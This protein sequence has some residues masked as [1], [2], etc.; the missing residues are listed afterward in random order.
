L[1][2]QVLRVAQHKVGVSDRLAFAS[3]IRV[4]EP[5][6]VQIIAGKIEPHDAHLKSRS[7]QRVPPI[8]APEIQ[9]AI[10]SLEPEVP[11]KINID[12]VVR[13][14]RTAATAYPRASPK[15]L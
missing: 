9:H 3:Q 12:N 10:P 7:L 1:E 2:R 13:H 15:E 8:P 11:P 6:S 4:H 14:Q 5:C